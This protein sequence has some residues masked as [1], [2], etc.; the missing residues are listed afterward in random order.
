MANKHLT[1]DEFC[2][3]HRDEGSFRDP[4]GR[5]LI[6]KADVYRGLSDTGWAKFKPV[7]DSGILKSPELAD[8]LLPADLLSDAKAGQ[9][10][11]S[12]VFQDFQARQGLR[13]RRLPLITYPY[14]WGFEALRA[15]ALAHLR[16]HLQLLQHGFTLSDAT[17]FNIQFEGAKPRH[18]DTLSVI[19]HEE[20]T[21]WLAYGQFLRHFLNP[22]LFESQTG[23]GFGTW[24]RGS[25]DGMSSHDLLRLLPWTARFRPSV[26]THVL[27]LALVER[28]AEAAEKAM[29]SRRPRGLS[30]AGLQA[31]LRH[32]E[33]IISGLRR[34]KGRLSTWEN[35]TSNN[36][37]LDSESERKMQ[38]VGDF[39]SRQKPA[40][41]LDIGCNT[42][43]YAAQA[44]QC[45]AQSVVGL[46]YDRG[47]LDGAFL[48]A[49][50]KDL[51][52]TPL[53][54]DLTNPSPAQGWRGR[55]RGSFDS[56][57]QAD[58]LVALAVIHHIVIRGNIPFRAAL[59]HLVSMAPRGIIEFVPKED[60]QVQ[61]MLRHRE[62][63]F[64]DY[65]QEVFL[66]TLREVAAVR[67]VMPITHTGRCL[68][69]YERN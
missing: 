53:S 40:L 14:E 1:Q 44:L 25:M 68:A 24:W 26:L 16:L 45:G 52:F 61:R 17:A 48:R 20:G 23:I 43:A 47:A 49:Q 19:P 34:P 64:V 35:Y 54:I 57:C 27:P 63:I 60:P 33:G 32:L 51:A 7:W 62:D 6:A 28:K 59:R 5:V 2:G 8:I 3:C 15:A 42:G 21:P 39:A 9:L 31:I 67:S 22:L 58:A 69:E 13:T 55:E 18:I 65:N 38:V 11:G 12:N 30:K 36:S 50:A 10:L 66:A 56:R 4:A 29:A 41:L 37:Y 46:E